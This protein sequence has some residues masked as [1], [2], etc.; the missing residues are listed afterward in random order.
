MYKACKHLLSK[1]CLMLLYLLPVGGGQELV[2]PCLAPDYTGEWEHADVTYTLKGQKAGMPWWLCLTSCL[3]HF[4]RSMNE[5]QSC[6]YHSCNLTLLH[7][8]T[9]PVS[10][11]T[12]LTNTAQ[13]LLEFTF[14]NLTHSVTKSQ[15]HST[16]LQYWTCPTSCGPTPLVALSQMQHF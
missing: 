14:T 7:F 11:H 13:I 9:D 16:L 6:L 12:W 2:S 3:T 10:I 15:I 8:P 1:W 5:I 4:P